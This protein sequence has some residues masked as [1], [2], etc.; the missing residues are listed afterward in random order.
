MDSVLWSCRLAVRNNKY[1]QRLLRLLVAWLVVLVKV[2]RTN[3]RT[4][5]RKKE[6]T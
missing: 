1:Q 2:E 5:E 3:E 6:N 4:D